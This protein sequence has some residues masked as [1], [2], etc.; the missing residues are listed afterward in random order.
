ML[1]AWDSS[2]VCYNRRQKERLYEQIVN[3]GLGG[4]GRSVEAYVKELGFTDADI[5]NIM[6]E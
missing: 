2:K 1:S 5:S 6:F 3:V 4:A